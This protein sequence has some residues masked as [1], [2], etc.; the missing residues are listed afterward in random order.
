[1]SKL[2]VILP[3]LH[4]SLGRVLCLISEPVCLVAVSWGLASHGSGSACHC[5]V[6][7]LYCLGRVSDCRA[8]LVLLGQRFFQYH[9]GKECWRL[10]GCRWHMSTNASFT[11]NNVGKSCFLNMHQGRN[12]QSI[13]KTSAPAI[14]S[15]AGDKSFKTL[16]NTKTFTCCGG[17]AASELASVSLRSAHWCEPILHPKVRMMNK[18]H[19]KPQARGHASIWRDAASHRL[20]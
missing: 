4:F 9:N 7:A 6:E 11:A 15:M 2:G 20:G 17:P 12:S 1:M 18:M 13:A 10:C 16:F 3:Q 5:R 14:E 8:C 19:A